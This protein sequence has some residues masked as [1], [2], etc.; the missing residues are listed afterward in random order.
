MSKSKIGRNVSTLIKEA[1]KRG[2]TSPNCICNGCQGQ[3]KTAI[4]AA[5]A[6]TRT[7]A[8]IE[9]SKLAA[10]ELLRHNTTAWYVS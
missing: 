8:G 10:Y 6:V 1:M 2:E 4:P 3:L 9:L 5:F 7:V